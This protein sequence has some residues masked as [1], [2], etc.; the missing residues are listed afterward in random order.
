MKKYNIILADCPWTYKDKA[1]AGQRGVCFKYDLLT[2]EDLYKLNVKN[3]A[4]E[5]CILFSW[6]PYPLLCEGLELIRKWGFKY[7]TKAFTW[8]KTN[9]KNTNTLFWGMGNWTRSCDE[10]CLMGIRGKPKR[11]SKSVHS[12]IQSPILSPHSRKPPEIR[13]RIVKL[14]GDLP[15]IE[16]FS[17]EVV[18]GWD[19]CGLETGD[20]D[21]RKMLGD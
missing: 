15:R 18:C 10:I 4:D 12:V 14:C 17:T 20:G 9:K 1:T 19:H 7:K 21:I 5:D 16:L 2:I 6:T 11:L 3:I 8:V 13:D